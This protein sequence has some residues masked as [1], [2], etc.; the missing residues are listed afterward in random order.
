LSFG[1]VVRPKADLDLDEIA[2]YLTQ[3][4]SLD[5]GRSF[6]DEAQRTFALLATQPDMGWRAEYN[7]SRLTGVRAFRVGAPFT[8]FLIFYQP[9]GE[10]IEILR[11]LHGA[12]DLETLF[13]RQ[14]AL[15]P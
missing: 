4:S 7:D 11:V 5:T 1:Y 12:Q 8:N 14:A 9:R 2:D 3:Q 13:S 15:N 6:L 10:R